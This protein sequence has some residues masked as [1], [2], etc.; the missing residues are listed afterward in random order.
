MRQCRVLVP[1]LALAGFAVVREYLGRHYP[2]RFAPVVQC[3]QG[4]RYHSLGVPGL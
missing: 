2:Q 1:V 3:R 4:Q